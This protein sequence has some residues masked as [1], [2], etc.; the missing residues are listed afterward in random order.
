MV[1]SSVP[2]PEGKPAESFVVRYRDWSRIDWKYD[3]ESGRYLRWADGEEHIDA[4][5]GEQI[6]AANVLV[7][8]ADH[9]LDTT[10]CEFQS[11]DECRAHSMEIRIWGQGQAVLFR[12]GLQYDGFWTRFGRDDMLTFID[13]DGQPL[14]LQLGNTWF[15]VMPLNYPNP[16]ETTS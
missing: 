9:Q 16:Y 14:P 12:D 1:F 15:Q 3:V 13:S 2:P 5:S 11:G 6:G 7:L 4:N 8:F 10:I